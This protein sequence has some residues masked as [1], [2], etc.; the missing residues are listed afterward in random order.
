VLAPINDVFDRLFVRRPRVQPANVRLEVRPQRR[1]ALPDPGVHLLVTTPPEGEETFDADS[2]V[3]AEGE[4]L[5]RWLKEEILS[6]AT[7]SAGQVA[8]LFRKLTQADAYLDALRRYDIPYVIEGEKHFYRRHEVIELVNVLRVLDHPHDRIALT[9][10]LRSPLGGLTDREL[11]EFH[12]AGL[13]DDWTGDRIASFRHPK[14]AAVRRL[15]SQLAWLQREV[16]AFSLADAIQLI[17]DRLPVLELAAASLHGEQAVANLLKVKQTAVSL[18]DRAHLTLSGFVEL[19][20]ERLDEQ[21]EEAESPLAEEAS[22]AVQ[23]LTIHKAKG[24]EFPIVVLAGLHQ[25]SGR[26]R[27]LP[28]VVYDW[29][30]GTYGL[31]LGSRR[32]FGAVVARAKFSVREEAERRRVLYVGMTRAKDL[33]VLSGG[34]GTRSAGES[35]LGWL[36]EIAQG[37]V[38]D[39]ATEHVRIG[40]S[41]IPHRVVPSPGRK[42]PKRTLSAIGT[43]DS[44]DQDKIAEL[45]KE[46]STRWDQVRRTPRRLT[47][48]SLVTRSDHP[49][50]ETR[51]RAH[52]EVGRLVGVAAHRLLERWEFDQAPDRLLDRIGPAVQASLAPEERELA[53]LVTDSLQGLFATFITSEVYERL[54]AATIL[55]REVPFLIPWGEGQIM[56]GVIDLI[57]R[58]DGRVWIADY[59]TDQVTAKDA[60]DR[61][62]VYEPQ[63]RIYRTAA[64]HC[65]REPIGGFEFVFLRPAVR[66][67]R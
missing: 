7:V 4:V 53:P 24:L 49:A 31:S 2:A 61:A 26:D 33:L 40:T 27:D 16:P 42:W 41:T 23:V 46:R 62:L 19:M 11:V 35:M 64:E 25:G 32:T 29:S 44:L 28:Y 21:P 58:L 6:R 17:F 3:R 52:Q 39:R 65:L 54:R 8:L 9:G 18:S 38:G 43:V 15:F 22:D 10:V 55:G 34:V 56:E 20:I 63:S 5:A 12:E 14:A 48:T 50:A 37:A 13:L 57:Y 67:E 66:V 1:A 30:S 47:P 36:Q 59:K 45:W 51:D 60:P